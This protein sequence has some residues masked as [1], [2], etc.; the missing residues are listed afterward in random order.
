MRAE[1]A[2]TTTRYVRPVVNEAGNLTRRGTD[3][4]EAAT[5]VRFTGDET[6]CAETGGGTTP[7]STSTAAANTDP[8]NKLTPHTVPA[9]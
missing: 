4:P 3:T 5:G 1:R 6:A 9:R 8:R 7:A 2:R